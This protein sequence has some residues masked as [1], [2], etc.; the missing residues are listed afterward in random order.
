MGSPALDLA[1]NNG[2]KILM[3]HGL[4]D[5]Q[6]PFRSNIYYYSKVLD[7]FGG[8][9]NVS[10]RY[11]F[12]LAPGVAHCSGGNGPQPQNLFNTMVAWAE[13]GPAP[14][15]ILASGGGRTRPLCAFPQTAIYD[16]VGNP[17]LASSF[18]CG[19]NIQT[20]EAICDGLIVKHQH[21]TGSAYEPL[22]G[23]DDVSCGFASPPHTTASLSPAAINGWYQHPTITL[24]ATD[25]DNDV[26]QTE[27]RLDG[28]ADWTTYGGPF[29]ANGDGNHTPRIPLDR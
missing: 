12:F 4:A 25:P 27:Y 20:Q 1:K 9:A 8:A 13:G 15:T 28:A 11:R 26:D 24:T 7:Y 5:N 23:E 18:Q 2:A 3:W 19:G 17:N 14:D 29:A 21:E 16:G 10:P 22:N 6:I